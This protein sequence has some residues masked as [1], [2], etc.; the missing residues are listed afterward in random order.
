MSIKYFNSTED[1]FVGRQDN[2]VRKSKTDV[3]SNNSRRKIADIIFSNDTAMM[4]MNKMKCQPSNFEIGGFNPE[5]GSKFNSKYYDPET[6]NFALEIKD[7]SLDSPIRTI[8]IIEHYSSKFKFFDEGGT[9]TILS[10]WF[11]NGTVGADGN[12]PTNDP[13]TWKDFKIIIAP[14]IRTRRQFNRIIDAFLSHS[15]RTERDHESETNNITTRI[16]ALRIA[17]IEMLKENKLVFSNIHLF[18]VDFFNKVSPIFASQ[19][20][21]YNNIYLGPILSLIEHGKF[22]D[23]YVDKTIE[24]G[25]VQ[26][27]FGSFIAALYDIP[28]GI[29]MPMLINRN[30]GPLLPSWNPVLTQ[31]GFCTTFFYQSTVVEQK[32]NTTDPAVSYMFP[33]YHHDL[34]NR[35][36]INMFALIP[37]NV[38]S[39]MSS[40]LLNILYPFFWICREDVNIL[41]KTEMRRIWNTRQKQL[42]QVINVYA[43]TSVRPHVAFTPEKDVNFLNLFGHCSL[44]IEEAKDVKHNMRK[45]ALTAGIEFQIDSNNTQSITYVPKMTTPGVINIWEN[46]HDSLRAMT[47]SMYSSKFG[48]FLP[49]RKLCTINLFVSL[50]AYI[51]N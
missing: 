50:Y 41:T 15:S 2:L 51:K 35:I 33:Q 17:W 19:L 18:S 44:V 4:D 38:D 27:E 22:P 49:F 14:L 11:E 36:P 1:L 31:S 8:D 6:E 24:G 9:D 7:I 13:S 47:I 10:Y 37:E 43:S 30:E 45:Y 21:K 48:T 20:K 40:E 29:F 16:N 34:R 32:N 26:N 42:Q 3:L 5:Y 28:D 23:M 46:I 25:L 12:F 39:H